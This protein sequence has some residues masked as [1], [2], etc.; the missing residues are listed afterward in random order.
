MDDQ[1]LL[2]RMKAQEKHLCAS[3]CGREL[4]FKAQGPVP[5]RLH[6]PII[7]PDAG[8]FVAGRQRRLLCASNPAY[9]HL[10][11][12]R[13]RGRRAGRSRI[14]LGVDP[15]SDIVLLHDVM[16]PVVTVGRLSRKKSLAAP[17]RSASVEV[18]PLRCL[19]SCYR[20]RRPAGDYRKTEC[21]GCARIGMQ[22]GGALHLLH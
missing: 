19:R 8:V 9:S 7:Q 16:L 12:I 15:A 20:N 2:S 10:V 17:A 3:S 21:P 18:I 11:A 6:E 4:H 22:A 14:R 5:Q 1:N 13:Y